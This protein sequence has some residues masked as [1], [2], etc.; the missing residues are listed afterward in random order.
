M[1][2]KKYTPY[3][4]IGL[5]LLLLVLAE[6]LI[7]KP[8]DW[9][10]T[11]SARDKN[12]YGAYGLL[13]VLPELFPGQEL[14]NRH[15]TFYETDTLTAKNYLIL[16][17]NFNPDREDTR[18]LLQKAA[19][20][21]NIFIAA[22]AFHGP[23]ADSLR[24]QTE[25][26]LF[27]TIAEGDYL[28][29]RRSGGRQSG[30][31]E[32]VGED[33]DALQSDDQLPVDSPS[34]IRKDSVYL[35]FVDPQTTGK[36]YA[37]TLPAIPTHFDS[38]PLNSQVLALNQEDRPVF[39]RKSWGEGQLYISSA[40]LAFSNYYL[41]EGE[42]HAFIERSL[43]YL[44]VAPLFW[45]E[46]YQLGRL[47]SSSPLRFVLRQPALRWAYYVGMVVLLLF[48]LFGLKR[49]QRSIP[50]IEAPRNTSLDFA[51]S[52][53]QL[54]YHQGDHL[55]LA[56]K[57][58]IYLK[59]WIRSHYRLIFSTQDPAFEQ[60]LVQK[61]GK[62]EEEVRQLLQLVRQTETARTFTAD[63]LLKL[64]RATQSFYHYKEQQK[65]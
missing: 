24:V 41:L 48:I 34:G 40:P 42:N 62:S 5:A 7:P 15:L 64:H 14:S 51:D 45:T 43:S 12:P 10:V 38:I 50:T 49:R 16:A 17:E 21:H 58:I 56:H 35:R 36:R 18:A 59:E 29:G 55:N 52:I 27:R 4:F 26:L 25:N 37:Y 53:G 22:S 13:Q 28:G 32:A 54:Y 65:V 3:L 23:F 6:L 8:L 57:K 61:T 47:E 60:Q 20:G 11:L 63:E 46:F 2:K 39:F 33:A 31:G 44:P 30:G 19:A 9:T 1:S